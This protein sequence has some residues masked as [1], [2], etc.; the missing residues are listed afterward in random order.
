MECLPF[1]ITPPIDVYFPPN[2]AKQVNHRMLIRA[3]TQAN[4]GD[5]LWAVTVTDLPTGQYAANVRALDH[6]G[7][8]G[9]WPRW[10]TKAA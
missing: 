3:I 10:L 2:A 1:A 9:P 4:P 6:F 7:I 8:L 5:A